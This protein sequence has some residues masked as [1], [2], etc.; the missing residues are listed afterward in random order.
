MDEITLKVVE[1]EEELEAAI[2]VRF[3]VF[4]GEQSIPAE[5]ELDEDDALATHAIAIHGG[6]VIG[7]GR[8]LCRDDHARIGR[9]AVDLEWR[10]RGIGGRLLGFLEEE[11]RSQGVTQWVLHSQELS[12]LVQPLWRR[13]N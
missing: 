5:E 4:V 3:R 6:A 2:G 1:T 11:A 12:Q 8:V 9:M 13:D 10:R 7:T